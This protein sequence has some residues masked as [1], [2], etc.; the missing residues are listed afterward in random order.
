MIIFALKEIQL[1]FRAVKI[2]NYNTN[3]EPFKI[4]QH[5][6]YSNFEDDGIESIKDPK[7]IKI[8]NEKIQIK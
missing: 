3:K 2:N 5:D 7:E 1:L 6:I 4:M 8:T